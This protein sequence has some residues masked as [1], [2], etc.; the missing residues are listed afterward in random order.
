M[1]LPDVY[2]GAPTPVT[3]FMI[4][5]TK[6]AAFAT[7]LRALG[8][9]LLPLP[10]E[11]TAPLWVL[12]VLTMGVGNIAAL[13][14]QSIKRML[15][16]SSIGHAG[17]LLVAVVAGTSRGFSGILFYLV[18]YAFMNLGAFAV[19]IAVAAPGEER[20]ALSSVAGLASRHPVLA[21]CMAIFMFSLAGIPPTGGFVGKLYIFSA[22]MEANYV[23]LAL[24][25]VLCSVI[26]VFFYLRVVVVMYME[27]PRE[28]MPSPTLSPGILFTL[29]L[30]M[31]VILQTGILPGTM[32]EVAV[33]VV[34]RFLG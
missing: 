19:I 30:A 20:P 14:Q 15:A 11:W 22:A 24:L 8:T 27:E 31:A 21:F 25:A 10:P 17:Y 12:A 28:E 34:E 13:T 18:V 26:A 4:A 5:G 23:G 32:W 3:A 2:E 6:A 7:L 9:A 33:R 16:Y 1:W 29:V